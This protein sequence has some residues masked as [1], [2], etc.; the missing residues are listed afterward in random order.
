MDT[1]KDGKKPAIDVCFPNNLTDVE[2]D[3]LA[4]HAARGFDSV[5]RQRQFPYFHGDDVHDRVCNGG[6]GGSLSRL[7]DAED[8]SPGR[9]IT[10]TSTLSGTAGKRRI[11]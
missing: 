2:W 4:L 7:A 6:S 1:D 5:L 10:C 11:G 3:R 8:G 9:S